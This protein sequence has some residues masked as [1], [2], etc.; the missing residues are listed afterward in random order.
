MICFDLEV[1]VFFKIFFAGGVSSSFYCS[2]IGEHQQWVNVSGTKGY[3]YV[4]DFVLPFYGSEVGFEVSNAVFDLHGC[5]FNMEEHTRRLA[6][7]EYSSGEPNAQ[8]TYLFRN[9]ADLVLSGKA[10][11]KWGKIALQTQQVVDACLQSAQAG[12]DFIEL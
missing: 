10:D 8:E 2:F 1:Y 12:G 6:V 9:F 3:L 7:A 11:P 4:D 5:E